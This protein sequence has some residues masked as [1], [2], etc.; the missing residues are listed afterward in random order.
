M[1][2]KSN[3]RLVA[4]HITSSVNFCVFKISHQPF[5][6][7]I[8]IMR[9]RQLHR[10]R[11]HCF[12]QMITLLYSVERM[13]GGKGSNKDFCRIPEDLQ[14]GFLKLAPFLDCLTSEY[15]SWLWG[16]ACRIGDK[17]GEKAAEKF[18][19]ESLRK[20][21]RAVQ[22]YMHEIKKERKDSAS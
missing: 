9:E 13:I 11:R 14:N 5:P 7:V 20:K 16:E 17:K 4:E 3:R 8:G 22:N 2:F 19:P 6:A 18:L 1:T 12:D 10:S 21:V 15:S